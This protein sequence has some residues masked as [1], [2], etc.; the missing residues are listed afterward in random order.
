MDVKEQL[1]HEA[2]YEPNVRRLARSVN[3]RLGVRPTQ[4]ELWVR[5]RPPS[6]QELAR[7]ERDKS[8]VKF[9]RVGSL[10]QIAEVLPDFVELL[11]GGDTLLVGITEF[12][13]TWIRLNEWPGRREGQT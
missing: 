5:V 6:N 13:D 1:K 12:Y 8:I 7:E 10:T 9:H 3:K 2:T 11:C 4:G